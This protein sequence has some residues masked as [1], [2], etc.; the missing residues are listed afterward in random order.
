MLNRGPARKVTIH[1]NEVSSSD[2]NFTYEQVFQFLFEKRVAGA[3]LIRAQEGF[4]SHHHRHTQEGYGAFG[5]HLPVKIE[6]IEAVEIVE[7]LLPEL[8]EI[9]QDGLIEM[10]ETLVVKA[11]KREAPF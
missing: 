6:F 2:R 5:R 3:T 9:V 1:L 8:C 11:A 10:L 7:A 4:G